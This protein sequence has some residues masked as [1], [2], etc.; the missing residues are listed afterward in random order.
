METSFWP[1]G[2]EAEWIQFEIIRSLRETP[3]CEDRRNRQGMTTLQRARKGEYFILAPDMQ[4]PGKGHGVVFRNIDR[5]LSHSR[6]VLRPVEG[7]FP[8]LKESPEL[9]Y[10]LQIFLCQST[11][12]GLPCLVKSLD[13][14][15]FQRGAHVALHPLPI[16]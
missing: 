6:R 9:Y 15:A 4:R 10:D 13:L 11:H 14:V 5:L 2:T 1:T 3:V 12:F 16:R 8:A 7:G